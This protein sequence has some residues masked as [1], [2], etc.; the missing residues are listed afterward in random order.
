MRKQSHCWGFI[1]AQ[2]IPSASDHFLM[3]VNQDVSTPSPAPRLPACHR[4]SCHDDNRLNF[5]TI[6]VSPQLNVVVHGDCPIRRCSF[7][8]C[9]YDLIGSML[10]WEWAL[11]CRMCPSHAQCLNLL[12][13]SSYH[14][15]A[16]PSPAP[17]LP[18]CCHSSP[19]AMTRNWTPETV[20]HNLN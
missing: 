1:Y 17:C 18:A 14:H 20:S 15:V 2:A 11:R 10:L 13:I 16:A 3:P 7:C 19:T 5:E 9:K 4:A 12:P 8:W 6:S